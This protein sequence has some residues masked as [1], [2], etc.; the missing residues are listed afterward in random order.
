MSQ[1]MRRPTQGDA[2]HP[3]S[4]MLTHITQALTQL[5]SVEL[6]QSIYCSCSPLALTM[7][8]GKV[9]SLTKRNPLCPRCKV[10]FRVAF[11]RHEWPVYI[12]MPLGTVQQ[13]RRSRDC[14]LC[15]LVLEAIQWSPHEPRRVAK[16]LD[17]VTLSRGWYQKD[18]Q[19]NIDI[20]AHQPYPDWTPHCYN[21]ARIT[22]IESQHFSNR[23]E[24]IGAPGSP[25]LSIPLIRG[26]L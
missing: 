14:A 15:Q 5:R 16:S 10:C 17:R 11:V 2:A 23:A 21:T 1:V 9:T 26:W 25:Q 12:V 18:G 3:R 20:L 19:L 4:P 22:T 13:L 8:G 24:C 7:Q 6:Y